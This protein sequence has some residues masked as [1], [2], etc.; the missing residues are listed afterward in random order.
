MP[1][2]SILQA[3]LLLSGLFRIACNMV[4][5]NVQTAQQVGRK[6]RRKRERRQGYRNACFISA[7]RHREDI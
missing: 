6:C 7:C 4:D 5:A 1:E 2:C 3:L